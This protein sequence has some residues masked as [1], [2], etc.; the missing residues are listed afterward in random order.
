MSYLVGLDLTQ[1]STKNGEVTQVYQ[2]SLEG[3]EDNP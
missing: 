3:Y 1:K 2:L